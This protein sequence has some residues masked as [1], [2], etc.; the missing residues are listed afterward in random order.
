MANATRCLYLDGRL[1]ASSTA[2]GHSINNTPLWIGNNRVFG[3]RLWQ[4]RLDEVAVFNRALTAAEIATAYS[5]ST[6]P[7]LNI[8][9]GAGAVVLTWPTNSAGYALQTN[10][11]IESGQWGT[12][13]ASYGISFSNFAVTNVLGP[14]PLFY[15]LIK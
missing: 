2:A 7:I 15:R 8:A 10:G 4:G 5:A 3:P 11:L 14:S 9:L 1:V 13:P 12:F 6:Y